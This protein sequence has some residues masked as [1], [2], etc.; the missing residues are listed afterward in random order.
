MKSIMLLKELGKYPL[1]TP[2]DIAKIVNKSPTYIRTLLYRLHRQNLIQRI[3][4]GKYTVYDDPLVYATY[5]IT[6]SYLSLWTAL[7]MY[8]L[9]E[10]QP[11]AVFVMVPKKRKN[12]KSQTV[13]I[14]FTSTKHMFG[15]R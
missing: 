3:E 11:R 4:K 9:T 12:I 8:N 5:L 6:P 7:R 1:F 13:D 10:Q 2:N 14:I 15:F